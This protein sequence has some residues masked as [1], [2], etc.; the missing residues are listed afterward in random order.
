[1]SAPTREVEV[2]A[3][4]EDLDAA[5]RNIERAGAVLV[6]DGRLRDRV[7]D[8]P[9]R[10]LAAWDQVL[11][12]RTYIS[13]PG[14]SAHLDWKG[15]T[16]REGGFK[17][18][19]ELTTSVSEPDALASVLER[20]GYE[21]VR[22]IDRDIAQYELASSDAETVAVVRFERYPRMDTLVEV[23]GPPTQIERAIDAL[24]I[25]R[26]HFS[27]DRLID[28]VRAYEARTGLR[29]AVCD[30]DLRHG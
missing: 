26:S 16:S 20:L 21:V 13:H 1:M 11:R 18:R 29:A 3:R 8:T 27:G 10:T 7:Y 4:V 15:P 23:E 12:L 22:E 17:V 14:V 30:R 25:P 24:A 9:D 28:F 2:K 19:S 6:F 5:R